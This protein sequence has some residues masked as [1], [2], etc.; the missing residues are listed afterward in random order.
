MLT[1]S[2][3]PQEERTMLIRSMSASKG[4]GNGPSGA[5]AGGM[6]SIIQQVASN[7]NTL[8]HNQQSINATGGN[9]HNLIRPSYIRLN[10]WSDFNE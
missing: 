7:M 3:G 5:G 2:I 8:A 9:S 4:G 1:S 10:Y 6:Q